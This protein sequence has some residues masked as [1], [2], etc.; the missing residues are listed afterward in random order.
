MIWLPIVGDYVEIDAY[1]SILAYTDL[2]N[3]RGKPAKSYIPHTPNYSVP[4][5]L[6]IQE[7]EN[8]NFTLKPDDGVIILDVSVPEPIN[9]LVPT[10]QILELIDHHPGYEEYWHAK[11]GNK[12]IIE[13]S[14]LSPLQFLN[15][16]V[17]VGTIPECL[18]KSPDFSSPQFSTIRS[19]STPKSRPTVTALPPKN[20]PKSPKPLSKNSPNGISPPLAVQLLLTLKNQF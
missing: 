15:G 17:N 8:P 5:E 1:A 16:G 13:K 12:A 6:R 20:S 11:I 14:V 9:K 10:S 3:Q 4:D 2:L 18:P 19:I 7:L